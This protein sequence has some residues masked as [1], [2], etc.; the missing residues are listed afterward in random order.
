MKSNFLSQ[1]FS[2][3]GTIKIYEQT[4]KLPL[5]KS[6]EFWRLQKTIQ[7]RQQLIQE[8]QG[9][10]GVKWPN[11]S[12]FDSQFK[13]L[14]NL[15]RDYD[16][17]I[18]FL[19]QYQQSF[20]QFFSLLSEDI[21]RIVK[22]KFSQLYQ[23]EQQRLELEKKF[24]EDLSLGLIFKTQ[25]QQILKNTLI[26]YRSAQL[27]LKK[28]ELISKSIDKITEDQNLQIQSLQ[29]IV[30]QL[31]SYAKIYSLQQEIDRLET[32]IQ[33]LADIA[34]NF[35]Q[36]FSNY[37]SPFQGL[38]TQIVNVDRELS[39]IVEQIRL[40]A[41]DITDQDLGNFQDS[42]NWY[43]TLSEFL[44]KSDQ[45]QERI[46]EAFEQIQT[47]PYF[48]LD[49]LS[50]PESLLEETS[51]IKTL[52]RIQL[53]VESKLNQF[54]LNLNPEMAFNLAKNYHQEGMKYYLKKD[55]HKT[56]IHLTQAINLNPLYVNAY[57]NRGLTYYQ[58]KEYDKARE[59]YNQALRINPQFIYAYNGRGFVYYE[60]KEYDKALEDYHQALT[61]NSQF[62]HAYYNR[63][64]VYC[65]LK[66]YDKAR[67]DYYKVLAI[68]PH[69]TDAY[70][71][72]KDIL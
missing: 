16:K 37:L 44:L 56:L 28:I 14:E 39:E 61:I 64:L 22:G 26:L 21:K 43:E 2:S 40:L 66:E 1:L 3:T 53:E 62:T 48:N 50:F 57:Y 33:K 60:L 34:I 65:D 69:Y 68:D 20:Q 5:L 41:E 54:S 12:N 46:R 52:N 32:D 19:Y 23:A 42:D 7:K 27:M 24:S 51:L 49:Q 45:K 36:N 13:D 17:I 58:L 31:T 10:K 38:I 47:F 6:R 25:K 67:E 15:I 63:G 9:L 30:Q 35:E 11:Q 4:Y 71:K 18:Q 29:G 55:Y 72:L 70:K 8:S 59:D